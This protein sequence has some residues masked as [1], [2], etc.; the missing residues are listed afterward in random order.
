MTQGAS[1]PPLEESLATALQAVGIVHEAVREAQE[2]VSV[3]YRSAVQAKETRIAAAL[4]PI[5]E[6]LQ[7][8]RGQTTFARMRLRGL[9]SNVKA[10]ESRRQRRQ[11]D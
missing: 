11:P 6:R 8:A 2:Q 9:L 5:A 3:S 10:R 7:A 1:P 4:H